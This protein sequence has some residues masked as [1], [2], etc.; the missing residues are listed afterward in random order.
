MN[1]SSSFRLR[2]LVSS[3]L[4]AVVGTAAEDV[5][6]D[7]PISLP[8]FTVTDSRELPPPESWRHAQIPNFEI[9]T[10]ASDRETQRLLRDFQQFNQAIGVVWPALIGRSPTPTTLI[11]CGRGG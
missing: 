3:L 2:M 5:A 4:L 11:L 10:N 9:L 6:K 8:T 1:F 7:A